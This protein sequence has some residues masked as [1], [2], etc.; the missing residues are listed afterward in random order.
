MIMKSS[1]PYAKVSLS[2]T[3][4][5]QFDLAGSGTFFYNVLT[6]ILRKHCGVPSGMVTCCW[7]PPPV[8]MES[9][10]KRCRGRFWGVFFLA[11]GVSEE[12]ASNMGCRIR[13]RA[14]INLEKKGGLLLVLCDCSGWNV[15]CSN[16]LWSKK[17]F[18]SALHNP[19]DTLD[20]SF[21]HLTLL[22]HLY[23]RE[24][25]INHQQPPSGHNTV[26]DTEML[27]NLK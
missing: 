13:L 15:S 12:L 1:F 24:R 7:V 10:Q 8:A 3:L 19:G 4:N 11:L 27:C 6:A 9:G 22:W 18:Y 25:K 5:P 26:W 20:P 2:K 21:I 14:L 16:V 23:L 17:R